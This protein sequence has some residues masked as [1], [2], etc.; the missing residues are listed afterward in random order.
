MIELLFWGFMIYVIFKGVGLFLR[1]FIPSVRDQ[2]DPS[3]KQNNAKKNYE[4]KYK[5]VQE[6]EYTE[7]KSDP[8]NKKD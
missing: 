4:S 8:D 6:V 7:I 3:P 1:F 2:S 5:D